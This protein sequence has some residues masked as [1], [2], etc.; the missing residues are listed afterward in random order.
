VT[1]PGSSPT[2]LPD[3]S[4]AERLRRGLAWVRDQP[5]DARQAAA[6]RVGESVRVA[7]ERLTA[8]SAPP[9]VLLEAAERMAEVVDLLEGYRSQRQYEGFAEGSG[10]GHD[11]GFFDWS[12]LMGMAN[13]HAPPIYV[14]VEHDVV[15][16][17]AHFGSAYEGPPGCVHGG[18]VA[19]AFD[20]V[21][22][23]TQSMSGQMG[24]TG[25]LTVRYRRPTPLHT[26]LRFE[27][28]LD[29]VSGRKVLTSGSLF[30][31]GRLTAEATGLFVTVPPERFGALVGKRSG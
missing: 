4:P 17:R 20:D 6:R 8:T 22:G 19:A 2:A 21:L 12:P 7:I 23:L 28:R 15:V 1:G 10:A 25:N 11:Q 3:E 29:S 27:G 5:L 30:A 9:E 26:D 14:D 31:E 24:M 16:G 18:V 13:P